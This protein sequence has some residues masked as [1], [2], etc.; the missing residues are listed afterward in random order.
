MGD[1]MGTSALRVLALLMLPTWASAVPVYTITDLGTL[2]GGSS[3]ANAISNTG[4]VVGYSHTGSTYQPF[5][6]SVE[7]GMR[8]ILT[9]ATG[10]G[11]ALGVNAAGTVVGYYRDA[12]GNQRAFS[13]T[14]DG[15]LVELTPASTTG[16]FAFDINDSGQIVGTAFLPGDI[17]TAY[18]WN[19]GVAQ[20]IPTPGGY[21]TAAY[22]ISD[23][24]QIVGAAVCTPTQCSGLNPPVLWASPGSFQ[25]LPASGTAYAIND[26]G[27]VVG[28]T[29]GPQGAWKWSASGG[30]QALANLGGQN[31][32]AYDINA[33][34][35]AVGQAFPQGSNGTHAVVWSPDGQV[36]DLNTLVTDLT[37]WEELFSATGIND[38]GQIVGYGSLTGGGEH[39]FLLT[40][41]PIPP[42]VFLFGSALGLMGSLR[43]QGSGTRNRRVLFS[44]RS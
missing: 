37:G 2:A 38:F 7:A 36:T 9:G 18:T 1:Y 41:V 24:G 6:W 11:D 39:A 44:S 30:F 43:R 5:I 20:P 13:W 8:Q 25:L 15:G 31:A 26:A 22:G 17:H 28:A 21:Q 34:G 10:S 27:T 14:G 29:Q 19:G 40:P 4:V 12:E 32:G 16:A 33:A 42:A 23:T 35:Y 3:A